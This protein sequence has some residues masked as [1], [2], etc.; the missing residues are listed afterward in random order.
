[1][2]SYLLFRRP[3][4]KQGARS[5]VNQRASVLSQWGNCF[6]APVHFLSCEKCSYVDEQI[7]QY[8]QRSWKSGLL[9][10]IS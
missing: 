4:I 8:F 9:N 7:F 2:D 3:D 1:M 6:S 5:I 10:K